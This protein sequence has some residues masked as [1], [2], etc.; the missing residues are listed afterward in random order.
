[1]PTGVL[2]SVWASSPRAFLFSVGFVILIVL[3]FVFSASAARAAEVPPAPAKVEFYVLPARGLKSAERVL[4]QTLQGLVNRQS[5][6]LWIDE[7]GLGAVI[8]KQ[9]R[10]EGAVLH[11]AANVWDLVRQ[12][13]GA[14]RGAIVYQLGT[15]SLNVATSLCGPMNA[16]AVDESLLERAEAEGLLVEQ[17]RAKS[18]FLRDFAVAHN[19]FTFDAIDS[20]TRTAWVQEFGPATLVYG[21]GRNV[22]YPWVKDISRGGFHRGHLPIDGH[23]LFHLD[24][25]LGVA[26]GGQEM[27]ASNVR[28]DALFR[29]R[30]GLRFGTLCGFQTRSDC[31]TTQSTED[32]GRPTHF[33]VLLPCALSPSVQLSRLTVVLPSFFVSSMRC[34]FPPASIRCVP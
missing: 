15:D 7:G 25:G 9:L 16:V 19:A 10:E 3:A 8:L 14:V 20:A 24:L 22:E 29:R 33:L 31:Q 28:R 11:N 1:M 2:K 32:Q 26:E 27:P 23:N 5:P 6:R 4:A 34:S 17:R 13:R 18:D 12:F 21:W 30:I